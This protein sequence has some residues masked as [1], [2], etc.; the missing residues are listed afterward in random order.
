[1]LSVPSEVTDLP[2]ALAAAACNDPTATMMTRR[3]AKG[4][5]ALT[6]L[7]MASPIHKHP[8]RTEQNR[9]TDEQMDRRTV[10]PRA[11]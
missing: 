9:R 1:L 8:D 10:R 5:L 2:S 3:N 11:K 4:Q 6:R 7:L